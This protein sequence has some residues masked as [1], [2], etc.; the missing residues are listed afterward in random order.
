[1]APDIDVYAPFVEAVFGAAPPERRIPWSIADRRL[2]AQEPLL[3]ALSEL[4]ALPLSRIT[5]PEVL[6]WLEVP[7]IARRLRL[8]DGDLARIRQWVAESGIRW[9]L[10]GDMRATM[11]LPGDDANSWAFG[12]RRLFLGYAMPP[13]AGLYRGALPYPDIEG[14]DAA[15]LG[16]LH[17]LVEQL[18]QWRER[19]ARA[20]TAAG[21]RAA[22]TALLDAL[23]APD[24]D[25]EA[26]LQRVREA[27]D[28]FAERAA[29]AGLGPEA[30]R[31]ALLAPEI[32]RDE[33]R[34][35]L[36]QPAGG[37]RFLT[38]AVTFCNMVPMRSIPA[39]V[40]CLLGM[41]GSAFP[42]G[43]RPL[44]F[45]LI[46]RHP[47]RG[48]RSRRADDR[49][50]FL[51]ALVSARDRLHI[52]YV[53]RDL[54]DNGVVVP[55]VVVD[56]LLDV[57]D[58]GFL[59]D[60]DGALEQRRPSRHI[61]I[62]HPLQPFSPRCFDGAD[63][64]LQSFDT[65]WLAVAR[66]AGTPPPAPF[67]DA[68]L[69]RGPAGPETRPII[70]LAEL[71]RF[72]RSPSRWFLEQRLRLRLPWD[73]GEL[74]DA[75]PFALDGLERWS[76][77]ATLLA[78]GAAHRPEQML[79]RLRAAGRLPHGE[80]GQ[81]LFARESDRVARFRAVL[82][83][84]AAP[85][86]APVE[87]D[88]A[89]PRSGVQLQGWV[90]GV[91]EAGLVAHRLGRRKAGHLLVLW[92][93]HLALAAAAPRG[94]EPVCHYL[95]EGRE[96]P[97]VIKL[98]APAGP[99]EPLALLDDLALLLIAARAGPQPLFP[100]CGLIWAATGEMDK[101]RRA[102]DGDSHRDLPGEGDDWAVR[103]AFRGHPDPLDGRFQALSEQILGPLVTAMGEDAR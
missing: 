93:H 73:D 26:L 92:L 21:W 53:G 38:G 49:Y 57:I 1:M 43:Q 40:I 15:A 88:L 86:L 46:A 13:D 74:A 22:V 50:L 27:L 72:V 30:G 80:A 56:E 76:V 14:G 20:H 70:D 62:E 64:R 102:W 44:G 60:G 97:E 24:E 3:A 51:E 96:G 42:R 54:R 32:L 75:E 31:D 71:A 23:L 91:T 37:Q 25:E 16:A 82:D 12:L 45:D 29:A 52:S 66:G 39:R 68:S 79:A 58:R 90:D 77:G 85:A 78:D 6:G 33:L 100:E 10:D 36:E 18:R 99:P 35:V 41:S 67:A 87:L 98:A 83:T 47:R 61:V 101:V 84:L 65:G 94:I 9:G 7:A 89:L 48:D 34:A 11:E 95:T 19:L 59:L 8:D 2:G 63:P 17:Y 28:D 103:T 69:P 55:S 81:V 5:A 4:L